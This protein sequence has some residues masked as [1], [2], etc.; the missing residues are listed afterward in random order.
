MT[1]EMFGLG[2]KGSGHSIVIFAA[3]DKLAQYVLT[4]TS[5]SPTIS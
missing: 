5:V 3:I 1:E 2:K 4:E